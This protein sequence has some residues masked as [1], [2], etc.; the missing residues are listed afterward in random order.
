MKILKICL[1][2][3]KGQKRE[4]EFIQ[5]G[6]NI[7]T[8]ASKRGKSSILDIVEYCLGASDCNIPHGHI[9]NT[10]EWFSVIVQGRGKQAFIARKCPE[11]STVSN[12]FH[13]L[14][15]GV[16]DTS[17]IVS[18]FKNA[19][20]N[21]AIA[22]L[23]DISGM[24]P[25][26]TEVPTEQTRP[27]IDINFKHSL[28]LYFQNQD[29]IASKKLIFHR[30]SEQYL[31]QMMVDTLPYFLGAIG[32]E[33]IFDQEKLRELK[34]K[35]KRELSKSTESD[36]IHVDGLNKANNLIVEARVANILK[37]NIKVD[38]QSELLGALRKISAWTPAHI[39]DVVDN[40]FEMAVLHNEYEKLVNNKKVINLRVH[41]IES[42]LQNFDDY[43]STKKEQLIRLQS[44]DIFKKIENSTH[45]IDNIDIIKNN[46]LKLNTELEKAKKSRPQIEGTLT[47]LKLEQKK[48][49]DTLKEK[50]NHIN[51]L[52]RRN[53]K[54]VRSEYRNIEAAK[55]SGKASFYLE[56]IGNKSIDVKNSRENIDLLQMQINEIE[57]NLNADAVKELLDSQVSIISEDITR[58][59]R[60]LK[61]EH[62][63]HP[64]K[65]DIK[66][67]TISADTPKGR[68]PLY[69]MG[70]GE[71]WVGYHLVTH[72]ALAKWFAEQNRPV[73][74]F[75]FIDQP[76]QV[77]FPS[78]KSASGSL[79]EISKDEDREAVR[80]MFYWLYATSNNEL[81]NKVQII[82][83]D[84]ADIDEHWFQDAICDVKWR[85]DEAL[86]PKEWYS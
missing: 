70:S 16:I 62:S 2:S 30:Q 85:G 66:K 28:F 37:E 47:S 48:L 84:H 82:I 36:S 44:I 26:R 72:V 55:I 80:R 43:D 50:R 1:F 64:I 74:N 52:S 81:K 49:S 19:N 69:Q 22:V 79:D 68:I 71:N 83:T 45:S 73:A 17:K 56:S 61:L 59:A 51:E 27:P 57:G 53:F 20:Q 67:L 23:S 38:T 4:L 29:E 31:P 63:E 34:R 12:D 77:Y 86:I 39:E 60:E 25:Y 76:S 21:D 40:E 41:E 35:L 3:R 5:P 54:V 75:L 13:I 14:Y 46:L 78:E 58:W 24:E 10:V 42:Y 33:R 7:I 9:R 32:S 11:N 65:L 6:L 15:E 18:I 8:G